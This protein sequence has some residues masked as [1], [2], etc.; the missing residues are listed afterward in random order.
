MT[1][2]LGRGASPASRTGTGASDPVRDEWRRVL[3]WTVFYT[4]GLDPVVADGRQR[5]IVSDLHEHAAWAAEQGEGPRRTAR[6]IRGRMLRG[7]PADLIW[8][9][10][11]V[12]ALPRAERWRLRADA[13]LI[14][15]VATIG[16]ALSLLGVFV[17]ARALRA[18]AIDDI[19]RPPSRTVF[20]AALAGLAIAG[21]VLVLRRRTRVAGALVLVVPAL[22]M[23]A[24]AG[25]VLWYVSASTVVVFARA[26]WWPA[27]VWTVA[28]GIAVCCAAA[29]AHWWSERRGA[30]VVVKDVVMKEGN[31]V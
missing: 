1:T 8:R 28:I 18:V 29:A 12:L 3:R 9:S 6:A 5:E 31:D 17:V 14:A 20:V 27:V 7:A 15:A 19:G 21:T 11:R 26:P 24:S 16:T 13:G 22:L 2:A 23:P 30:A 4:R 10:G 25:T